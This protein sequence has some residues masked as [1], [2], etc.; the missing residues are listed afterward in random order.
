MAKNRGSRIWWWIVPSVVLL[1]GLG[2]Y[3]AT[4]SGQEAEKA[5]IGKEVSS[6]QKGDRPGDRAGAIKQTT[7]GTP[8]TEGPV[9]I[10]L[11]I[12]KK[13]DASQPS[14]GSVSAQGPIEEL[15]VRSDS[16][17]Q[18]REATSGGKP[19]CALIDE[20]VS[21]FFQYVD[22]QAYFRRFQ[23]KE[24]A[25]SYFARI[26]KKL[27]AHPPQPA[28]EGREPATL[29]ANIYFFFRTMEKG[30][31]PVI[32]AIM[33]NE[34][35]AMEF[36]LETFYRWLMLGKNCPNPDHMRPDF[37]VTYRYAGFLLNTTGGRASLFRRPMRLRILIGYYCVLIVY[38]ADR[39]GKNAYGIDVV[40]FL[41]PLKD[42]M[43]HHP[44]LE[45][46]EQYISTLTRIEN[47]YRQ[48]R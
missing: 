16:L 17:S 12:E 39:L 4:R 19:Y 3:W 31:L 5:L 42:E 25:Q 38:Q 13:E 18:T 22:T 47:Y 2:Y 7:P 36:N 14:D 30:D 45:F 41:Q 34:R 10:T 11:P 26:S 24:D 48:R 32:K 28:G 21:E 29:L 23:L 44:E 35:D 6:G 8:V 46:Q 1:A 27:S 9:S 20:Q 33:E 40:P 37:D 15:F 43:A